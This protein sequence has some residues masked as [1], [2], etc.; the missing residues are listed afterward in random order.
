MARL[1]VDAFFNVHAGAE[2]ASATSRRRPGFRCA[3]V[4]GARALCTVFDHTDK[5][6]IS[7]FEVPDFA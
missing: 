5:I 1:N 2:Y 3:E 6:I 4:T 7:C